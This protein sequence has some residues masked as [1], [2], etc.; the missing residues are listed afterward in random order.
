MPNHWFVEKSN[1]D[2]WDTISVSHV[3][4]GENLF[5]K[6]FSRLPISQYLPL[7]G[8]MDQYELIINSEAKDIKKDGWCYLFLKRLSDAVFSIKTPSAVFYQKPRQ[9]SNL[10]NLIGAGQ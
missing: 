1:F 9:N 5:G 6:G 8:E 2:V 3:K 7:R 10:R 4:D